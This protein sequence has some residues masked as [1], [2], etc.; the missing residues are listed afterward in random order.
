MKCN[1]ITSNYIIRKKNKYTK[2]KEQII[3]FVLKNIIG[4]IINSVGE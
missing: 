2:K 4:C 3:K 1:I